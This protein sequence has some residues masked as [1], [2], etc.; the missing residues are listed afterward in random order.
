VDAGV[1]STVILNADPVP[2]AEPA[3]DVLEE[4]VQTE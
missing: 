2:V 1:S 4:E 3:A